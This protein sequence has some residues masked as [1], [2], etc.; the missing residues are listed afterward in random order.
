[1][2]DLERIGRDIKRMIIVDNLK[3]NYCWQKQNGIHIKS[4]YDDPHDTELYQLVPLLSKIV[5]EGYDDVREALANYRRQEVMGQIFPS[6]DGVAPE[7]EDRTEGNDDTIE[8]S[9]SNPLINLV[10]A[11]ASVRQSSSKLDEGSS[12]GDCMQITI[13]SNSYYKHLNKSTA[14]NSYRRNPSL[15]TR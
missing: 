7:D 9:M 13:N 10:D 8:Q 11:A 2:K 15:P 6:L 1:M 5:T 3:E 14:S 12:S 4:W